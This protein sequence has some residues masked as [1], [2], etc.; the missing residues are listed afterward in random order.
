VLVLL[1]TAALIAVLASGGD[2]GSTERKASKPTSSKA[3]KKKERKKDRSDEPSA[4]AAPAPTPAPAQAPA[5]RPSD[6]VNSFYQHAASHDYDAAWAMLTDIAKA[7]LGSRSSFAAGQSTLRSI[8]FPVLRT[9]RETTDAATVE[10]RSN[11]VHTNRTDHVCGTVDLVRAGSSWLI[12]A[13]HL[14]TCRSAAP[15]GS[16]PKPSKAR[17][18][19]GAEGGD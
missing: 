2:D 12:D 9:T 16:S 7:Q 19:P 14:D 5:T 4:A 18:D 13:L 11:A 8:S 1:G 3:A 6:S 10:L 17:G 15:Q